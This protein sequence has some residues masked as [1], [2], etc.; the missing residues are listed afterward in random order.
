MSIMS[1]NKEIFA[2]T[3]K[4]CYKSIPINSGTKQNGAMMR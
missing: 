4:I 3:D 2:T 1:I